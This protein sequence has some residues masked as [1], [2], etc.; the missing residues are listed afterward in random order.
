VTWPFDEESHALQTGIDAGY[1]LGYRDGW[2]DHG[3]RIDLWLGIVKSGLDAPT[4]TGL[5]KARELSYDPCSLKCRRCSRCIHSLAYWARGGRD[6]LGV[7]AEATLLR[8][9]A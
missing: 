8:E 2:D 6:Y 3:R 5:A 1:S 9:A 4:Q 7:E